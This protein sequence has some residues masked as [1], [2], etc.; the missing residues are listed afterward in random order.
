MQVA[1]EVSGPCAHMYSLLSPRIIPVEASLSAP[2]CP[3]HFGNIAGY[4]NTVVM[5]ELPEPL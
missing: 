1:N 5:M 2:Q 4:H 3:E